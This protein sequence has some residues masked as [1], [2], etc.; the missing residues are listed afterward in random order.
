MGVQALTVVSARAPLELMNPDA[1]VLARK[2]AAPVPIVASPE[3]ADGGGKVTS[4]K[5]L[6]ERS[7]SPG[8]A[9]VRLEFRGLR[10]LSPEGMSSCG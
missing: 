5:L 7:Q 8:S 2:G 1:R 3:D 9:A 4:S 10:A 6:S